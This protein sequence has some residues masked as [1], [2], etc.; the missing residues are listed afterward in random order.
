MQE[1][2]SEVLAFKRTPITSRNVTQ[3][4]RL[5]EAAYQMT[6]NEKRLLMLGMSKVDPTVFPGKDDRLNFTLSAV[7]W[8]EAFSTENAYRD[9]SKAADL[10]KKRGA[11]L[12]DDAEERK[13]INWV[14]ACTYHKRL[15]SVTIE[16]TRSA[17]VFLTGLRESFTKYTFISAAKLSSF[18]TI[19]LWEMCSQYRS[20]GYIRIAVSDLR[21]RLVLEAKF[22]LFSDLRK[23][24]I[25]PACKEITEKTEKNLSFTMIKEGRTVTFVE[26]HFHDKQQLTLD[27]PAARS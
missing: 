11:V 5:V 23:W 4:N 9:M 15:A 24:V 10:L 12:R 8:S 22:K 7:E 14:E 27:L 2:R 17:T 19:R 13:E 25:E 26:F 3:A 16:F 20:T 1:T 21:E 6:L 18:Y